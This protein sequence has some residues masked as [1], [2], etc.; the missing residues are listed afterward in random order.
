MR[1]LYNLFLIT[2]LFLPFLGKG[3]EAANICFPTKDIPTAQLSFQD[4][5]SLTF[6]AYYTWGLVNTGV[7]ELTTTVRYKDQGNEP[8]FEATAAV[9]S[10]SF[11][12]I[13]FKVRDTYQARFRASN[14]TPLYFYRDIS[15]GKYTIKNRFNFNKDHSI[16]VQVV[17]SGNRV[18]DTIMQGKPCTFDLMSLLYFT[19]NIDT[20]TMK[21]QE[22]FSLSFVI[23]EEMHDLYFRYMGIELKKIPGLGTFRCKKFSVSLVAGVVFSGKEEMPIWISDDDNRIPIWLESPTVRGKVS[24]RIAKFEGLKFPLTSKVK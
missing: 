14:L 7:G 2:F 1:T 21:E 5:E 24:A 6:V 18:K 3:Q 12:D 16:D 19:R 13:F 15:E 10:Y 11:F 20:S 23:D 9:K 17:R 8:Y 22:L 4:G